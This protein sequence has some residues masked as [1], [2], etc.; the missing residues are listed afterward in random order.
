[1]PLRNQLHV[2]QLL[3]N[4]SV[5]YFN[6]DYIADQVF[7]KLPVKKDSDLYRTYA[8]NFRLP[9]TKRA[10]KGKSREHSFDVSTA[11]Y[12]LEKHGLKDYV[13]DDEAENYDLADLRAD[14]TE[15]LTD[16][17][18]RRKEKSCADL[19]TSANWSLN[20]SLAAANAWSANT[21]VSNPIPLFD[22]AA[23]TINA[24][25]G[26]LPNFGIIPRN[27]F[28]AAKNHVS[29]LDRVKYT[30]KEMNK[31]IMAGLFD[32]EEVLVPNS[33]VDTSEKGVADSISSLWR[34]DNVFVGYREKSPSPRKPSCGYTFMKNKPLVKRWRDEER[35]ADAIEV[36]MSYQCK[37]IASLAGYLIIDTL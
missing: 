31:E 10:I 37:I 20:V 4:I 28:V 7:G 19:F 1:M 9:E 33:Q 8:R 32:L 16:V 5:K 22:T 30:S 6:A 11:S 35:E 18:L 15:E 34:Q 27:S 13:A 21:T 24:N 14:T 26:F 36:N 25:S 17:I 12:V 29:V 2:D 23:S 3:S